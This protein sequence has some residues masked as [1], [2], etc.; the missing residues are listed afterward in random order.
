MALSWGEAHSDSRISRQSNILKY[1]Q[2]CQS[3]VWDTASHLTTGTMMNHM[4]WAVDSCQN[5]LA[6][7]SEV[8][9][10]PKLTEKG[11]SHFVQPRF[12]SQKLGL[13][14]LLWEVFR[15][16]VCTHGLPWNSSDLVSKLSG[17]PLPASETT[18]LTK[19][20]IDDSLFI[21]LLQINF[22]FN[23]GVDACVDFRER[24]V[25]IIDI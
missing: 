20:F 8:D 6:V 25:D 16:W 4:L 11:H 1:R 21:C 9:C 10:R 7:D 3:L 15:A 5:S 17:L 12:Y 2:T 19:Y 13:I 22:T 18:L 14:I 23:F 24:F